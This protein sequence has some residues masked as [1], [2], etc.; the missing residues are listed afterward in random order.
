MIGAYGAG[1]LG[2]ICFFGAVREW[3]FPLA[4]DRPHRHRVIS[5]I[6]S[7][8][9][10]SQPT[11]V[12]E[13][14]RMMFEPVS[15]AGKLMKDP[16]FPGFMRDS[17]DDLE[18]CRKDLLKVEIAARYRFHNGGEQGRKIDELAQ[19]LIPAM[20]VLVREC[21]KVVDPPL[22]RRIRRTSLRADNL[23]EP[24]RSHRQKCVTL[25]E[26]LM[27]RLTEPQDGRFEIGI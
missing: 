10:V 24:L 21:I 7:D 17:P 3:T 19:G 20:R 13:A 25:V 23:P 8:K 22:W 11:T 1:A 26:D 5:P 6:D 27:P 4:G 16:E 14:R 9:P 12:E 18:K 2:L 15:Q